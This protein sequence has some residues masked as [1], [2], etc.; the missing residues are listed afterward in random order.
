MFLLR[1]NAI[2][3][4]GHIV[5]VTDAARA[6]N[7]TYYRDQWPPRRKTTTTKNKDACKGGC[8]RND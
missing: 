3:R 8:C 1:V 7:P 2:K 5:L 6:D 4:L